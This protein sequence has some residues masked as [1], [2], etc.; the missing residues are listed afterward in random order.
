[1][2]RSSS[3]SR[4]DALLGV[5]RLYSGGG[6]GPGPTVVASVGHGSHTTRS[7]VVQFTPQHA[8]RDDGRIEFFFPNA[9]GTGNAK[10]GHAETLWQ[11]CRK[12][13]ERDTG[14]EALARRVYRLSYTPDGDEVT[15]TVGEPW[16][17]S[18]ELVMA[19]IAFPEMYSIRCLFRGFLKSGDPICVGRA[20]RESASRTSTSSPRLEP[21]SRTT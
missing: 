2:T 13:S 1:M 5:S 7:S 4:D 11:A 3:S 21:R 9:E 19:I 17:A 10:P 14:Q 6:F 8:H 20:R 15:A 16:S 18:G 12:S